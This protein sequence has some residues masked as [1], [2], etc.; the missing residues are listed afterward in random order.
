MATVTPTVATKNGTNRIVVTWTGVVTGDTIVAHVTQR[1][2]AFMSVQSNGTY[3]GGTL[4]GFQASNDETNFVDATDNTGDGITGKTAASF[5]E[6]V[7]S[8]VA[9]KPTVA[10]GSSDSVTVTFAYWG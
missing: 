2:P 4:F 6:C 3:N 8:A 10:S 5:D 7:T 9:Y 1:P